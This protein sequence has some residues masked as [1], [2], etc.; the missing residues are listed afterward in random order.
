MGLLYTKMKIFYYKDKIDSLSKDDNRI[1]PPVHIRIKPTNVCGHNC[2][3]C[4]YRVDNLQLG[5]DMNERDYI[6]KTKM[7][8]IIDD[9]VG[10]GVK[11]VTFSG[12]GDP[13]YYP[14]LLD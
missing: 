8:E 4:A 1:L 14:Y 6:P 13:F 5:K 7:M 2:R 3:Y 12:G 9:V 10:M 11:A